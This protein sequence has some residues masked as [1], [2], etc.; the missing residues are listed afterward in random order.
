MSTLKEQQRDSG[1]A[2]NKCL[3]SQARDHKKPSSEG[4]FGWQ[5]QDATFTIGRHFDEHGGPRAHTLAIYYVMTHIA[6]R[7]NTEQFE[8]SKSELARLSGISVSQVRKVLNILRE[9]R[10]LTW[11]QTWSEEGPLERGANRY[12]LLSL[13]QKQYWEEDH[14]EPTEEA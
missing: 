7:E 4:P 5:S 3:L 1:V 11:Q 6:A 10:L 13:H 8:K 14:K 9:L 2:L 12:K